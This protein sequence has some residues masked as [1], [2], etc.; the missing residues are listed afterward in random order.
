MSRVAVVGNSARDVVDGS[1]PTPGGCPVF[2][3]EAFRRLGRDGQIVT[4]YAARDAALFGRLGTVLPAATTSGFTIDYDGD[5][6]A[7]AM[8]ALGA[9]WRPEDAVALDP[10]VAWVHVAPLSRSDFPAETLATLAR[11]RRLSLDAQ[12]LVRVPK[13]GPLETDADY[14]PAVLESVTALKLSEEEAAIVDPRRLDVP[15]ILVTR[16]SRGAIVLAGGCETE[17]SADPV[18]DVQTT[19]AGDVFMVA[20]AVGRVDGLDPVAAAEAATRLV[21]ELL[22]ERRRA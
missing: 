7:M 22:R 8:T 19:G 14:D 11:G 1:A 15:E 9:T 18:D 4:R 10:D 2:A 13:L 5:S 17:V 20:Y 16:G 12:G 3:A 21:G 6:R